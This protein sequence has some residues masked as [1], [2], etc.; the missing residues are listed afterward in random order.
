MIAA[1]RS[2]GSC[3]DC[4]G[5]GIPTSIFRQFDRYFEGEEGMKR[6]GTE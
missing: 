4:I 5:Q 6:M 1:E 2:M 3:P